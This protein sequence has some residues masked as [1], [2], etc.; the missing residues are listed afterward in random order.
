[1]SRIG[2][3]T[4]YSVRIVFGLAAFSIAMEMVGS[5]H[6]LG[7]LFPTAIA[8]DPTRFD[9]KLANEQ[10]NVILPRIYLD[11]TY[12]LTK[13]RPIHV[14]AMDDL[15]TAIN[16]AKCGDT[17]R[18]AVGSIFQGNFVLPNKGNCNDW[19]VIRTDALDSNL[20]RPGTRITPA[21]AGS[22]PKVF[23]QNTSPA[24]TTVS[25]ANHY[26]FVGVE[27]GVADSV[28]LNYGVFTIGASETSGSG[29]PHDIIIDRCYIHGTPQG[30]VKRGIAFNGAFL[31]V[32]DSY[33]SDIHVEG[34]DTQAVA[35]W[36]GPGPFKIVNN[37]LEAAGE[38]VIFGGAR[39]A[40]VNNIPSDIEIRGNHF[41]KP[42][43]WMVASPSYGGRHWAVK[44]LLELKN[45]Q[46]VLITGNILE[47]N[48]AD[49]QS[50]YA[51]LISPRTELGAALGVYVQDIT[52]TYNIIRHTASGIKISGIDDGDPQK[53]VRGRRILIQNNLFDDI[54]GKTWG[55]GDGKLF[56]ILNGTDAV[57]IDHNTGFQNN[58]IITVD[59]IPSTHFIY[60]NNITP[61]NTYGIKG[62]GSASGIPS[63]NH[64]FPGWIFQKNVIENIAPSKTPQSSYPPGTFFPSDWAAVKFMDFANGNYALAP[65]SPYKN[66][67]TDGKN[68]GADIAELN[69]AAASGLLH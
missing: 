56:Q 15:Q 10:I 62:S 20:P 24:I 33:I 29:L 3:W 25:G 16:G 61:H 51:F 35:G 47:N 36:N 48:W 13:E 42:L 37:E 22:M 12:V 63:L 69:A 46:R 64:Y 59:G 26:R 54:N 1:V 58:Q 68:I 44:N 27:I 53:L 28:K 38:N 8:S 23:S 5:G 31:A 6:L 67:G 4:W 57:T 65:S 39:P 55:G 34:Q 32:I 14:S 43:S 2:S 50:G 60:Q 7:N 19:I 30:N 17:I 52:F 18:L 49:G 45:A 21:N 40:L 66:A 41:S 9:T 11:T